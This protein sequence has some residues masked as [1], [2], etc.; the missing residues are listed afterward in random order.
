MRNSKVG[1]WKDPA[2]SKSF[3]RQKSNGF[4]SHPEFKN[5]Q[6][7]LFWKCGSKCRKCMRI[8]LLPRIVEQMFRLRK[9][10]FEHR[11]YPFR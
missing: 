5:D 8:F 9:L 10:S 11:I 4:F 2:V 3:R 1:N 7:E 6:I